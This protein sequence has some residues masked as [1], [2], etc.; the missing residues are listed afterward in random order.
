[1]TLPLR[2]P[3]ISSIACL[4]VML[5]S[6]NSSFAEDS[7]AEQTSTERLK[8]ARVAIYDHSGGSANGPKNLLSFLTESSGFRCQRVTPADIRDG[9]LDEMDVLIMPGGSASS[10]ARH[11]ENTGCE[12]IRQFVGSGGGYVGICAGAYLA[13]T[14]Y[15]WSLGL[16]N[17]RVWDRVHWARGTGNVQLKLTSSGCRLLDASNPDVTVMYGQGPLLLPD[18]QPNLPGYEV[19]A[20]Y[21]SE[22][23]LKGAP[24]G[25]M[26]NT[27][28]IIRSKFGEGRVIC[29]SPHPE[30]DGGPRYLMT[31]GVRWAANGSLLRTPA[32]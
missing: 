14:Q 31:A 22:V 2:F 32:E 26:V 5:A 16:I 18:L 27:H 1:M 13:S 28:A 15:S 8:M 17:A 29:F 4:M 19:L 12:N 21:Q 6:A 9:I 11:L 24:E 25:A 30:K 23:A 10:Q 7:R 20:A 3:A